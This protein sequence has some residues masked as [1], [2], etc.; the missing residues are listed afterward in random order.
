MA[1]IDSLTRVTRVG[2]G[3]ARG[4]TNLSSRVFRGLI[5]LAVATIGGTIV[6]SALAQEAGGGVALDCPEG[7]LVYQLTHD[8]I[9][10][11]PGGPSTS[12]AGLNGFAN[13]TYPGLQ[14]SVAITRGVSAEAHNGAP[15]EEFRL[16][17]DGDGQPG[18]IAHVVRNGDSW[19]LSSFVACN[20]LLE[21]FSQGG[22][23]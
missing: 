1:L 3:Q 17:D 20:S 14:Q 8:I 7:D 16:D 5:V 4:W 10:D 11:A 12:E 15:T 18:A 21:R 19:V 6:G 22:Q 2:S 13:R 23:W 9:E